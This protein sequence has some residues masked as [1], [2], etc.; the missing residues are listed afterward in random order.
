MAARK[1]KSVVEHRMYELSG[2]AGRKA[3]SPTPGLIAQSELCGIASRDYRQALRQ[4][5][6]QWQV[7]QIVSV[8]KT[9]VW[10]YLNEEP[11]RLVSLDEFVRRW[12]RFGVDFKFASLSSK[13]GLSL[14]GFYLT[15]ADGLRERPLIFA[16]TAH[17]HALVALALDHEMG[18]HLTAQMFGSTEDTS[19]LLSL[20]VFEEHLTDPLE[21]AADTLVSFGIFPAPVARAL[22]RD[23]EGAAADLG[24]P[25][26]IFAKVIKYI[27]DRYGVRIEVIQGA[28]KSQTLAAL[29]HY[30]KLR[31]ALLDE[32]DA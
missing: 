16:N 23:P 9:R 31:Q 1:R 2:P 10:P 11:V 7:H 25:D 8:A 15:K 19:H 22:F 28:R 3:R 5:L 17:H 30:A 32:Y 21:L 4:C 12:S 18:H 26:V 6:S 20:T 29:V 27:T 24:L 13:R 14:L